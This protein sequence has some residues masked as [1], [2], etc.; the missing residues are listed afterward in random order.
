MEYYPMDEDEA[1]GCIYIPIAI[2]VAIIF[3][4][5]VGAVYLIVWLLG[6]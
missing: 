4:V 6:G 2:A 3:A 1:G 5:P